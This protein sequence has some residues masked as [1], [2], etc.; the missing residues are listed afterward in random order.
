M[1]QIET[2]TKL[3]K[4]CGFTLETIGKMFHPPINIGWMSH[5]EHF[6]KPFPISR[7]LQLEETINKLSR[8]KEVLDKENVQA[9]TKHLNSGRPK[10]KQKNI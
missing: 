4:Q 6:E 8:I 10:K 9:Q 1:N 7:L 5:I 2:L 3:R